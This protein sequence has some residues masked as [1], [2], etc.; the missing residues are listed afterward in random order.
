M[1]R[2]DSRRIRN[3]LPR[4]PKTTV[5][6]RPVSAVIGA[7]PMRVARVNTQDMRWYQIIGNPI[8][9]SDPGPTGSLDADE[10]RKRSERRSQVQRQMRDENVRHDTKTQDLKD[11]LSR[12]E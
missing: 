12:A 1:V 9:E 10:W 11:R 3:Y 6:A 8:K 2:Q 5:F 4:L 7:P